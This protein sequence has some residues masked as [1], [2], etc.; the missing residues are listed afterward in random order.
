[1]HNYYQ[2]FSNSNNYYSFIHCSRVS[3]KS[4]NY[5]EETPPL[6]SITTTTDPLLMVL[7][8]S[9]NTLRAGCV[10]HIKLVEVPQTIRNLYCVSWA[11]TSSFNKAETNER[12]T[13][14]R[15]QPLLS[16][17]VDGECDIRQLC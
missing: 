16:L 14:N 9:S 1:M 8:H 6:V 15:R 17:V 3:K 5:T 4:N 10:Q 12:Q 11:V 7:Q 2:S 13:F